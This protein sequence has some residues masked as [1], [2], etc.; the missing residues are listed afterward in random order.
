MIERISSANSITSIQLFAVH[1]RVE[2]N[3]VMHS[4]FSSSPVFS[5]PERQ[6]EHK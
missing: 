5:L 6:N 4:L 2:A 1:L 3:L